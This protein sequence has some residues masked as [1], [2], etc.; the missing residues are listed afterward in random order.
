MLQL[1]STRL[2]GKEE[3]R[4]KYE[5]SLGRGGE[6][7][8]LWPDLC[9]GMDKSNLFR[10]KSSEGSPLFMRLCDLGSDDGSL[11]AAAS[12]SPSPVSKEQPLDFSEE[13]PSSLH[14]PP[15]KQ[16]LFSPHL[17]VIR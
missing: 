17:S 15:P 3:K 12:P 7:N 2:T 13:E 1:F 9:C 14:L 6:D 4:G 16:V 11:K 5:K 8:S 10:I